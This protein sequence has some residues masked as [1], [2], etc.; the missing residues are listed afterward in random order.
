MTMIY[1]DNSL[2]HLVSDNDNDADDDDDDVN[3]DDDDDDHHTSVSGPRVHCYRRP[4]NSSSE[5]GMALQF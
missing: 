5:G 4:S 1:I 2:S 3:D